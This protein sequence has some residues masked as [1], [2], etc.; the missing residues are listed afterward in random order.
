MESELKKGSV[1]T[2]ESGYKYTVDKFLGE[3]GQ[4]AVYDVSRDGK[5]MAL[6]W[7]H[8]DKATPAQKKILDNLIE[9]GAPDSNFL[10]PEDL[11]VTE[12]GK[13]FGYIMP[14][15]PS[16][17]T[18]PIALMKGKINPSFMSLCKIAYNATLEYQKLHKL[19][20]AY[21]DISFGNLFFNVKT[22]EVLICDNDNVTVNG[23]DASQVSGTHRFMAPEIVTGKAKPSRNTDLFSLAVLLFYMFMINHPLEGAQEAK[24][25]CMDVHAMNYLYGQNPVFIF[26][27][28]DTS[29]RP[30]RGYQ[31]N[32]LI[33][34][35]LIPQNLKDLFTTSFT[36]GIKDPRQR[37]TENTWLETF[38]NLFTGIIRCPKCKYEI[39]Y[40]EN[41]EK[42]GVAHTC[43]HC[44]ST[45]NVPVKMVIG[46]SK[47]LLNSNSKIYARHT[48]G[49]NDLDTVTGEVS[50]N[51][52][53]PSI[54]GIRNLTNDNWTYIQ[55]DGTQIPVPPGRN[56]QILHGVK[57]DFGTN[58]AEF[59]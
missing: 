6:K 14:L 28:N 55:A 30:V 3:G 51:P 38:S 8:E 53:D 56:A 40:D 4:G 12:G 54:W 23:L 25:K 39:F 34:W 19:G 41:K 18:S 1:F 9:K 2:S 45:A 50:I 16:E 42:L 52:N 43:W 15:R 26:D 46:R 13:R 11:I 33:Y 29:N 57:L 22:G 5:H 48:L 31:D 17:Y 7:Y 20:Y 44:G 10:W 36:T 27:P 59:M 21:S 35:D 49:N 32:A 24:I 47:I 37:V 58:T